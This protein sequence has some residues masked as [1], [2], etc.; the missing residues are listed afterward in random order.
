[1]AKPV[2]CLIVGA[3]FTNF[4]HIAILNADKVLSSALPLFYLI[5]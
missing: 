5:L 4:P 1:M 3:S 2:I